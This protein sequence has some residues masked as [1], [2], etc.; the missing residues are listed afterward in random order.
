MADDV[1]EVAINEGVKM[2]IG[3]IG[4]IIIAGVIIIGALAILGG[5]VL[6]LLVFLGGLI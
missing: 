6:D 3:V 2:L 4:S 5:T 1:K